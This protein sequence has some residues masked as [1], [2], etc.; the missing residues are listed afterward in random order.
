MTQILAINPGSTSTKISVYQDDRE[1]FTENVHHAT[2]DLAPFPR[3]QDQYTFRL[4][5]IRRILEKHSKNISSFDAFVGRGGLVK[6]IPS[7]TYRVDSALL[8]DLKQGVQGEHASNLGGILAYELAQEGNKLA[9][10]VDPVVVDELEDIARISGHPGLPRKSIFHALNQKSVARK[11][12]ERLQ[13]SY[14]DCRLIVAHMG[15]GI[16]IAAHQGGR[17]IDV[18]NALDGEGPFT[19]ERSGTLP[20]GDLV[21]LCFSGEM[22]QNEMLKMIKGKGGV[23]AYLNTNDMRMVKQ[24]A[25]TGDEQ[26][27]LI[28]SGMAYQISKEI[29]A[30]GAVL[31]GQIDAIV[32]TGGIAHNSAVVEGIKKRCRFLAPFLLFP[33]EKEMEALVQGALRVIR[34]EEELKSYAS[35]L[36]RS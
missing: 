30:M 11:A 16:S 17:V 3:I 13:K 25:E 6:P 27:Q 33:G 12:A 14:P 8:T 35:M 19:P 20:V 7:G 9:F 29:A 18:N 15:G 21:R 26:A 2:K 28:L 24:R 10:I 1:M 22:Q 36:E 23:V 34:E 5:A 4:T 31:S 32:L